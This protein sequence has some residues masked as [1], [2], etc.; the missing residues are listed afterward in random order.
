MKRREPTK[1]WIWFESW[2]RAAYDKSWRHKGRDLFNFGA[3]QMRPA[4]DRDLP[5]GRL[6]DVERVIA[7]ALRQRAEDLAREAAEAAAL[8]D[9]FVA[10]VRDRRSTVRAA[11]FKS[12]QDFVEACGREWCADNVEGFEKE[13]A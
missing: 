1:T 10:S 3:G 5:E 6:R 11:E 9:D 7:D 13:A 8:A 2:L 4:L 12:F